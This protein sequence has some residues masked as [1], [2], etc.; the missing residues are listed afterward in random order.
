VPIYGLFDFLLV[1][2]MLP[3]VEEAVVDLL[4]DMD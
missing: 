4:D 2:M 3:M 1:V